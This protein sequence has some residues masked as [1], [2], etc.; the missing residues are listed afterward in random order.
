MAKNF[1][2]CVAV[3]LVFV[4]C[5]FNVV[6]LEHLVKYSSSC[7]QLVTF[8]Q[9]IFIS[10]YGFASVSKFGTRGAVVPLREYLVAVFYFYTSTIAGNMALGCNIS[11]PIQMIFKA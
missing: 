1:K 4:A 2:T 3:L 6:S 5:C 9:F 11:M 10:I 7:G 8:A